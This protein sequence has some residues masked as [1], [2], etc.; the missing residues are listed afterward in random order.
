MKPNRIE[1]AVARFSTGSNCAQ[2]VFGAY[3]KLLGISDTDA[4]RIAWGF[5]GGMGRLQLTCGAVTGAIM[6]IGAAR[7]MG[8]ELDESAKEKTYALVKQL[9][10]D[11]AKAKGSLCCA[12]L[13]G[14]DL[15]TPEG[16]KRFAEENMH[17]L[18]CS[19][20]VREGAELVE[21]LLF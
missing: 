19:G 8:G 10:A 11:F 1:D 4:R 6:L 13:L 16:Q 12:D 7:G 5:G 18:K 15:N 3:A 17:G 14:L 21:K 9:C 20:Y 2:A